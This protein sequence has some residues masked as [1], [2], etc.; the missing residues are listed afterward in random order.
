VHRYGRVDFPG[1]LRVK[2]LKTSWPEAI[3]YSFFTLCVLFYLAS[4]PRCSAKDYLTINSQPSGATVELDGV[5][6]GKTP[7]TVE[8]PGGYLH[9]SKSVF[10]KL[11]RNQIHL[12]LILEGYLAKEIDLATGPTPWI[13][14]NGTYHGDYWIL[15]SATFNFTLESAAASFT[16]MVQATVEFLACDDGPC[17]ID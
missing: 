11:L 10:G 9:G 6:V 8:I 13:A 15:K 3:R 4:S 14:L 16:G 12:K 7:Y 5:V 17:P 1:G 2:R